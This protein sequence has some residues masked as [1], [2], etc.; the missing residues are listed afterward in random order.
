MALALLGLDLNKHKNVVSTVPGS[1]DTGVEEAAEAEPSE[2]ADLRE[3][4]QQLAV[5]QEVQL[6][7]PEFRM[8]TW[9]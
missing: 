5:R 9:H 2:Y 3:Y 6:Q 8:R 1:P 4:L 7:P